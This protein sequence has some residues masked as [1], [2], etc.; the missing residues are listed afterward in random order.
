MNKDIQYEPDYK[1]WLRRALW[2]LNEATSL[3]LNVEPEK[4][5]NLIQ[6][7]ENFKKKFGDALKIVRT[8]YSGDS[9]HPF[10]VKVAT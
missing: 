7:D 4:V 5:G 2:R 1:N 8:A 10:H 3:L 6:L 9:C